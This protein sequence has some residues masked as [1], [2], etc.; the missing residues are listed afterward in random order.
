MLSQASTSSRIPKLV[1][2]SR[3]G[4]RVIVWRNQVANAQLFLYFLLVY[5]KRSATLKA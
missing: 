5:D 4:I 1:L 3:T 2:C